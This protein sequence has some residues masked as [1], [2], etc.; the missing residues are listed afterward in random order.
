MAKSDVGAYARSDKV[1]SVVF[2]GFDNHI[3]ELFLRLGASQWEFGG[4]LSTL[5]GAPAAAGHP[6]GY[7]R[8][9]QINAVVY[10][11]VDN[12]ICELFLAAGWRVNDLSAIAG[13][14]LAAGDP[15]AHVR[16]DRYNS[17]VYRG[18]DNHI[19]E[20][21]LPWDAQAVFGL[22]PW[23]FGDLSAI[24]GAPLAAGN[25]AGYVRGD[26]A[27]SVVYRG[28][29]NHIY[30]LSLPSGASAWNLSDLS[31]RAGAPPAQGDPA[32]YQRSDFV[33]SV[34]YR[35]FDNHI[36]ELYLVLSATPAWHAEDLSA[37]AMKSLGS[38][39]EDAAGDPAGYVCSDSVNSVV[40]RGV[41]NN[42]A[43][44]SLPDGATAWK[45]GDLDTFGAPLAAGVP[46]TYVRSD[47]V[48]SVL[49]RGVDNHIYE[50][51][52]LGPRWD[53]GDL[54]RGIR[55]AQ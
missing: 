25:P 52:R 9:D 21:F 10:R 13:A 49:Y 38:W 31:A 26:N 30:E 41:Y 54:S 20:L 44:F 42:V 33:S 24:T 36:H 37:A 15:A 53:F 23:N 47:N 3:Y 55:E 6:A 4:S 39:P 46:A 5:A 34:V 7:A 11:G 45:V 17:V 2:R 22:F 40:Y 32:G 50:F 51:F 12:H 35:G 14:P 43:E 18:V 1:N 27:N 48:N 28:F 29:D 19:Y 8:S 16:H